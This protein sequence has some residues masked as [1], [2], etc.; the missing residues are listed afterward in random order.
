MC[1]LW[2]VWVISF[3]GVVFYF[4]QLGPRVVVVMVVA[5]PLP[6]P[7]SRRRGP[8]SGRRSGEHAGVAASVTGPASSGE[9]TAVGE[10]EGAANPTS[11]RIGVRFLAVTRLIGALS[12]W[13]STGSKRRGRSI[14]ALEIGTTLGTIFGFLV[15]KNQPQEFKFKIFFI[16]LTWKSWVHTDNRQASQQYSFSDKACSKIT[17]F[18]FTEQC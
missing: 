11:T 10:G 2:L 6:R 5:M 14:I 9:G 1:V 17:K 4:S 15:F 16:C 13:H 8:W 3:L 7:P 18:N 12:D